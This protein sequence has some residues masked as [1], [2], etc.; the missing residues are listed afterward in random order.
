M[1]YD[2]GNFGQPRHFMACGWPVLEK[3]AQVS[4]CVPQ[5]QAVLHM[6]GALPKVIDATGCNYMQHWQFFVDGLFWV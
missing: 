2:E 6:V 5:P 3:L 1:W 4:Y